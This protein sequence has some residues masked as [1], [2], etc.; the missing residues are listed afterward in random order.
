MKTIIRIKTKLI[1]CACVGGHGH[2]TLIY[3]QENPTSISKFSHLIVCCITGL[4][5]TSWFCARPM[6]PN[7]IGQESRN[8]FI[9][10]QIP[11]RRW[12]LIEE[13]TIAECDPSVF[14]AIWK[15]NHSYKRNEQDPHLLHIHIIKTQSR[16]G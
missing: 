7:Y 5:N 1:I 6:T 2:W 11:R 10:T 14:D 8:T 15:M 3:R 4:C 12:N 9:L 16:K 13:E